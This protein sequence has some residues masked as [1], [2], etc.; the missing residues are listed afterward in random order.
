[1]LG[2]SA[3]QWRY[4][5]SVLNNAQSS[6]DPRMM[7]EGILRAQFENFSNRRYSLYYAVYRF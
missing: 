2:L 3:K 1:M 6:S 7:F 4:P 5:N